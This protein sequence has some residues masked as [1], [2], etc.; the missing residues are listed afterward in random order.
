[1][2]QIILWLVLSASILQLL[3]TDIGS[4]EESLESSEETI[5]ELETGNDIF[6]YPW[7][8]EEETDDSR[9]AEKVGGAVKVSFSGTFDD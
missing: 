1:M 8:S 5:E 2:K 9:E 7:S 3:A 4:S 6:E